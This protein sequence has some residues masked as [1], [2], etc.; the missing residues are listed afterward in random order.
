MAEGGAVYPDFLS[1]NNRYQINQCD[2][3]L[4][5][6]TSRMGHLPTCNIPG[7]HVLEVSGEVLVSK[8]GQGFL[9]LRSRQSQVSVLGE[10]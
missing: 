8:L 3:V 9:Q 5:D 2:N 6:Y 10:G 7:L 4:M 1:C